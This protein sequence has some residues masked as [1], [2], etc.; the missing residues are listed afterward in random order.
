[1]DKKFSEKIRSLI[2]SNLSSS[3]PLSKEAS[4]NFETSRNDL[5]AAFLTSTDQKLPLVVECDASEHTL[6]DT[7]NQGGKPVAFH[8]RM[9]FNSES[10]YSFVEKRL[11]L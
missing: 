8:S 3:F 4:D 7:L 1:M 5:A 10:R 2:Q 11:Q 6:A 9:F